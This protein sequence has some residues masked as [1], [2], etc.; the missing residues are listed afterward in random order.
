MLEE[1]DSEDSLELLLDT[2]C[3]AF[4]GIILITLLIA[5]M[6]Q[7]AHDAVAAP[8]NYRTQALIEE[9]K[10]VRLDDEIVI[11]QTLVSKA[12]TASADAPVSDLAELA[13]KNRTLA[14]SRDEAKSEIDRLRERLADTPVDGSNLVVE[15]SRRE[16]E[17]ENRTSAVEAEQRR[18]ESEL[19]QARNSLLESQNEL[20]SAKRAR[21]KPLRLPKEK[22]SSDK[23]PC[24]VVVKH[25]KIYPIAYDNPWRSRFNEHLTIT[26][27]ITAGGDKNVLYL[28]KPQMGFDP[29]QDSELLGNYFRS[30]NRGKEYLSF[31]LSWNDACFKTFN[32]AKGLATGKRVDYTW[33]PIIGDND[34][35]LTTGKGI[36]ARPPQ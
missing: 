35:I 12:V 16:N 1:D 14:Q 10:I 18:L 8:K 32:Q 22:T 25:G 15:L 36:N 29:S 7:E 13:R 28:P 27:H 24:W 2:L 26:Q 23:M 20:S 21:T 34:L 9:Q 19:A 31:V 3:N 30:L 5:L 6:S 4:G 17:L 33:Q 11:E